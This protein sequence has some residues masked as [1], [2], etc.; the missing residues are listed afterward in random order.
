MNNKLSPHVTIY[1]FPITAISSISTRVSGV[2]FTGLFIGGGITK[3]FNKDKEILQIY[4][5]LDGS[6]KKIFN[7]SIIAPITYHTYGGIRHFIW[8]KYP[9]LLNNKNVT[10]H[11]YMLFGGTFITSILIES[12]LQYI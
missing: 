7:Y 5:K 2:Y 8:D 3:Y 12:I 1:K 6:I 4:D 9:S 11:S 10:K